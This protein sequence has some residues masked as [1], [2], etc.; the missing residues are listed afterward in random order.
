MDALFRALNPD[1][2]DSPWNEAEDFAKETVNESGGPR[3]VTVEKPTFDGFLNTNLDDILKEAGIEQVFAC[4]LITTA[5][6]Q[7][8]VHSAFARWYCPILFE[9]CCADRT[10]DRHTAALS[11][12]VGYMYQ[13]ATTYDL[14]AILNTPGV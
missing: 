3:E 1:K 10:V 5:C 11:L 12:Y 9:V 4:G 6:V 8:T 2:T 7:H 13:R 14:S